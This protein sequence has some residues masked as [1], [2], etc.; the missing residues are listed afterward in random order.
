VPHYVISMNAG[1][2]ADREQLKEIF[3][4]ALD[5]APAERRA[6]IEQFTGL[7]RS[8]RSELERL[9]SLEE[10]ESFFDSL[11][12]RIGSLAQYDYAF[13]PDDLVANRFRIVRFLAA[14]GMGQVYEAL[15]LELETRVALKVLQPLLARDTAFVERFRREILLGRSIASPNVCRTY[16]VARTGR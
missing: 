8:D 15:D 11:G 2:P 7:A 4:D 10:A 3:A 5:C 9:L 12:A 13:V 16:D 6:F 14:G 1:I